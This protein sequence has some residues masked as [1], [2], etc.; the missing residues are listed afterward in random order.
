MG[1]ANYELPDDTLL[2]VKKLSGA[3][4]KREA[5]IIALN[6]YIRKK[7]IESLIQAGGQ[8]PLKWTRRTLKKY[9]G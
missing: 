3:E 6:E 4:T 1:K 8:I 9:R 5:I 7:K 2:K